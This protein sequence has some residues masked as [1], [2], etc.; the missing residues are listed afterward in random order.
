MD[1]DDGGNH[2]KDKEMNMHGT[3]RQTPVYS[4]QEF[5]LKAGELDGRDTTDTSVMCIGTESVAEGLGRQSDGGDDESVAGEGGDGE[6]GQTGAD[7]VYVVHHDENA[8]LLQ[9]QITSAKYIE[10]EM[11]GIVP[12]SW[13][14]GR[15]DAGNPRY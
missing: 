15:C 10:T 13:C 1:D 12:R 4:D 8:C 6:V 11:T 3:Y 5:T 14:N 2:S 9:D 7:L